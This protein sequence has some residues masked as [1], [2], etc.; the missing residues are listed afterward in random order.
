MKCLGKR[1]MCGGVVVRLK[2]SRKI[3]KG[4]CEK[5]TRA[6]LENAVADLLS[7]ESGKAAASPKIDDF[8]LDGRK[9]AWVKAANASDACIIQASLN[10]AEA[11]MLLPRGV[12]VYADLM[13]RGLNSIQN[14]PSWGPERRVVR[15]AGG[16]SG[17][18][19]C[20]EAI[21][22]K[23]EKM[24][25]KAIDSATWKRTLSRRVQHYGKTF[26]YVTR[27][28]SGTELGK[29]PE[30]LK[31]VCALARQHAQ[32]FGC[33]SFTNP[34]QV[35]VNEYIPGQ[36]INSHVDTHSAFEQP[37]VSLSMGSDIVMQF[38]GDGPN[39]SRSVHL[40]CRSMLFLTGEA[41]FLWRHCINSRK[42]DVVDDEVVARS[43]RVS[44]TVR[45]TRKGPCECAYP[46]Q[47]DSQL[48]KMPKVR[49]ASQ[50]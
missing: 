46:T 40:P 4:D 15:D 33:D 18:M 28:A 1:Q 16:I 12:K 42:S 34:N 13:Q 22:R 2:W 44:V 49:M 25:I 48:F 36:G 19:L 38:R 50:D 30:W 45:Q 23:Q 47:C 20:I 8:V 6:N 26:D 31:A 27:R 21:T 35:T 10:G 43:R 29:W 5:V 32:A 3:G 24:W 11:S 9:R 37:I 17:L 7:A 39:E 14:A 41:R